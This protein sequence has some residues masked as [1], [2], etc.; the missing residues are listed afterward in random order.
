[1]HQHTII[2]NISGFF[3]KYM[4][5]T[6]YLRLKFN[7]FLVITYWMIDFEFDPNRPK[8]KSKYFN[9]QQDGILIDSKQFKV[10]KET[11]PKVLFVRPFYTRWELEL[12]NIME[13]IYSY[14]DIVKNI[15]AY[16]NMHNELGNNGIKT[17][18]NW[19]RGGFLIGLARLATIAKNKGYT[20]QVFDMLFEDFHNETNFYKTKYGHKIITYGASKNK[21]IEKINCFGPDII[22]IG[23]LY[24]K[25]LGNAL[26]VADT[27]KEF[28]ENIITI[29]GGNATASLEERIICKYPLDY[30]IS[31]QAYET[32]VGLLGAITAQDNHRP[33]NNIQGITYKKDNNIIKTGTRHFAKNID[34][35]QNI[36]LSLFDLS[37]YSGKYHSA[38][39]R[40]KSEG[41]LIDTY[42]QEG[43][44]TN[45]DFCQIW[46]E[47][48]PFIKTGTGILEEHIKYLAANG[49]TEIKF[50]DDNA[51]A[52]P[53][54]LVNLAN[55]FFQNGIASV[56]EGGMSVGILNILNE[57]TT[58]GSAKL[59]VPRSQMRKIATALNAKQNGIGLKQVL[60]VLEKTMYSMYLAVETPEKEILRK[61]GKWL[62]N[63]DQNITTD[64]VRKIAERGIQIVVGQMIGFPGQTL[65]SIYRTIAYGKLLNKNGANH[66]NIFIDTM[67]N[68]TVATF[69]ES[70][71]KNFKSMIKTLDLV[72]DHELG[73]RYDEESGWGPDCMTLARI[74]AYAKI[75]GIKK[76]KYSLEHLT[77][78]TE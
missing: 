25:Q 26:D 30:I 22:A 29:L 11:T 63:A 53:E 69:K 41:Y 75:N 3:Y 67:L 14:G 13:N 45:C 7:H 78:P 57:N 48:G 28:D 58:Y 52:D 68:G 34:T 36:D 55:I 18:R 23:S 49:V 20:V 54:Y 37:K 47:H 2:P 56:A 24:L 5:I 73:L 8:L 62:N 9:M 74:Y 40:K 70:K 50:N 1:M 65:N 38:G 46:K 33:L 43:C 15:S 35:F 39:I 59:S 71:T 66:S 77:W 61:A 44:V 10:K 19:A 12:D 4:I 76:T 16:K 51:A 6:E 27:I 17:I 31:G 64:T 42:T 60:D 32:I 72:G 21:L